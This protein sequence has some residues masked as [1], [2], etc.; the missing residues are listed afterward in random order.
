MTQKF[1]EDNGVVSLRAISKEEDLRQPCRFFINPP[2]EDGRC[3]VCGRQMSELTPFGGPGDPLPGDFTGEKLVKTFRLDC[4]YPDEIEEAM[5]KAKK[6]GWEFN[7]L[8][9]LLA[10]FSEEESKKLE[11]IYDKWADRYEQFSKSWECRDCI[12]LGDL[13]YFEKRSQRY[14]GHG[15]KGVNY[16]VELG[17]RGIISNPPSLDRNIT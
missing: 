17:E 3:D 12:V 5:R 14:Q 6:E 9:S 13:E 15:N 2:P 11:E 10:H 8:E 4:P 16:E 7:S 1:F